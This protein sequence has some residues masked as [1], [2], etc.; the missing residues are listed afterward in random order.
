M[1]VL[2]LRASSSEIRYAILEKTE[3]GILFLN[4]NTEHRTVY[5]ANISNIESKL[6][7]AYDEVSR[8]VR[9]NPDMCK[10]AVKTNEFAGSETAAKRET[11]YIDAMFLLVA[12]DNSIEVVRRLYSQIGASSSDIKDKAEACAGRTDKYWNTTMADAIICAYREIRGM[13]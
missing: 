8:I 4:R 11:I 6:K 12:A 5:P 2:G 7:W 10:I 9:Q 3:T 1:K 13:Y